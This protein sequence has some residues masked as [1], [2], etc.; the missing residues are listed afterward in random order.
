M[1]L[2]APVDEYG[3]ST[4]LFNTSWQTAPN[5]NRNFTLLH[6]GVIEPRGTLEG[7]NVV[8]EVLHPHYDHDY[9]E[10]HEYEHDHGQDAFIIWSSGDKMK[11]AGPSGEPHADRH[12]REHDDG[13]HPYVTVQS[14][15]NNGNLLAGTRP[16]RSGSGVGD[17][18][19][20]ELGDAMGEGHQTYGIERAVDTRAGVTYM[21]SLDYAGRLGY[22]ADHTRIGIY[23]DGIKIASYASTSPNEALNWENLNFSFTGNGSNQTIKIMI[24]AAPV[25]TSGKDK[26]G[27][28]HQPRRSAMI[29]N[30]T[31]TE[32]MSINSGYEG[33]AI[34]LSSVIAQLTDTD[35]SEVMGV[36]VGALPTGSV[37]SDGVNSFTATDSL[38]LVSITDW[39]LANLS[40]TAPI[41]FT[42]TFALTVAATATET[43]TGETASYA[44]NLP[45]TVV[46][47][48]ALSLPASQAAEQ[49]HH[50]KHEQDDM[51]SCE[52]TK[53]TA[54][55][56]ARGHLNLLD[57]GGTKGYGWTAGKD[58]YHAIDGDAGRT[59]G[60]PDD[61]CSSASITL[62]SGQAQPQRILGIPAGN[63]F[64]SALNH[65]E[66]DDKSGFRE[67]SFATGKAQSNAVIDWNAKS[68]SAPETNEDIHKTCKGTT[69]WFKDFLGLSEPISLTESTGLSVTQQKVEEPKQPFVERRRAVNADGT[70]VK[71]ER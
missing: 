60:K 47:R 12:D 15:S 49:E 45:V 36:T 23:I 55:A 31:L 7:W 3:A 51:H 22:S 50:D 13:H 42:G 26:C 25:N 20:L 67:P 24:E 39:N 28:E 38:H 11:Q 46:Q 56:D 16:L 32:N 5:R 59:A 65:S 21:L 35:G 37:L 1:T 30:L 6:H 53:T 68:N 69:N 33:G 52:A 8:K 14:T 18:N 54:Y 57:N 29:D 71:N 58:G 70:R 34:R 62:R 44:L 61:R 4:T 63:A 43:A 19:W 27:G 2:N 9:H 48:I 40:I 64:I 10:H 41:G 66:D 17:S